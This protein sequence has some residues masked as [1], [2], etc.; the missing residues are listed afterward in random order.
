VEDQKGEERAALRIAGR[1]TG[2]RDEAANS[3]YAAAGGSAIL[4]LGHGTMRSMTSRAPDHRAR[5]AVI[6][7]VA[8][9]CSGICDRVQVELF[10]AGWSAGL[11]GSLNMK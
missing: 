4:Q 7:R 2:E 6:A 1:I 10:M 11:A 5:A 9:S 8:L 3:G